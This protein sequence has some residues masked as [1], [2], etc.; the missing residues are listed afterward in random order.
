MYI[1]PST[2]LRMIAKSLCRELREGQTEAEDVFWQAARN[3]QILG[4]KFYRQYPIFFEYYGQERFFIADFC[5][6]ERKLVIEID[7]KIHDYQKNYD[8]LR[9]YLINIMGIHVMRFRNED[10][11]KNLDEVIQALTAKLA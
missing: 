3:R 10:I 6:V 2:R 11:L 7:G 9:T 5:C 1:I 4:L 8:A